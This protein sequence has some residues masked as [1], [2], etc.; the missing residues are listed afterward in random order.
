MEKQIEKQIGIFRSVIDS[1]VDLVEVYSV[2]D[3]DVD[4]KLWSKKGLVVISHR[5]SKLDDGW[6]EN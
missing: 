4:K 2:V 3:K 1:V 6:A 5:S